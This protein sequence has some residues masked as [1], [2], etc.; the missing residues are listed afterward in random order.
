[1]QGSSLRGVAGTS[2]E[3]RHRDSDGRPNGQHTLTSVPVAYYL[4]TAYEYL[5]APSHWHC[6]R[7]LW[8]HSQSIVTRDTARQRKLVR[9]SHWVHSQPNVTP[10]G[11][12]PLAVCYASA[13]REGL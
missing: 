3:E 4:A 8:V 11:A 2:L 5:A 12:L 7:M 1:M 9:A 6:V 10:K 13:T